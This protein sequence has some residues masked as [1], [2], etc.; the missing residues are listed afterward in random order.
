MRK[1]A[2]PGT[3]CPLYV[4]AANGFVAHPPGSL[5]EMLRVG[6]SPSVDITVGISRN[7]ANS[8][9]GKVGLLLAFAARDA[10]ILFS[11]LP[12]DTPKGNIDPPLFKNPDT[13]Q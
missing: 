13:L 2:K 5:V 6:F 11:V 8:Q 9:R 4:Y 10:L 3:R 7:Q 12:I 1:R